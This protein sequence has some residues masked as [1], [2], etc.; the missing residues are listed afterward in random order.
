MEL[1]QIKKQLRR[2]AVLLEIGGFKPVDDDKA[3]WFG[4]VNFYSAGE[5]WPAFEG[6]PLHPLCQINLVEF[7]YR[8]KELED[9]DFITVFISDDI[10]N[11]TPNGQGWCLRTYRSI[12]KL[13]P[14]NKV[15][16]NSQIKSFQMRPKIIEEDYPCWEDIPIEIPEEIEENYY[17]IFSNVS[18]FKFGGWPTLIQSEIFWAPFNKHPIKPEFV[19]QIDSNEKAN[20]FWGDNG[21]GYFARGTTPGKENEWAFSCQ[22]Y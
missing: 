22:C 10:P 9:I 1:E 5:D 6:K 20:W 21:A 19:F 15:A 13:V 7:P 4:C 3:S 12:D 16:T 11:D 8:M 2:K 14:I 18:G 17:D